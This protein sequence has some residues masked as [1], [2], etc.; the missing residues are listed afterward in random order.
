MF[1]FYLCFYV[2]LHFSLN[3]CKVIDNKRINQAWNKFN[4][5]VFHDRENSI[6]R[7]FIFHEMLQKVYHDLSAVYTMKLSWNTF[8]GNDLQDIFHSVSSP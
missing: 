3:F 4:K 2:C 7:I 6:F 5:K 1:T 8:S